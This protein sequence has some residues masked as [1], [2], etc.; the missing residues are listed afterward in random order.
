MSESKLLVNLN[1]RIFIIKEE[2]RGNNYYIHI[3]PF[4]NDF[5][6]LVKQIFKSFDEYILYDIRVRG[7]QINKIINKERERLFKQL[8]AKYKFF[9]KS[10][11]RGNEA[12]WHKYVFILNNRAE[13]WNLIKKYVKQYKIEV[14]PNV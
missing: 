4:F 11:K 5:Q 13:F 9:R 14:M 1:K 7:D 10:W 2:Q 12:A 6:C 8:K 3:Y